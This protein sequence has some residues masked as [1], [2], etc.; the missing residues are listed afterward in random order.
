MNAA[1]RSTVARL[2]VM[3]ILC[4]VSVAGLPAAAAGEE[5]ALF[6]FVMNQSGQPVVDLRTDELRIQQAGGECTVVGLQPE[7]NGMKIALLVD[8]TQAA[9]RSLNSLRDGLN[10]FLEDLPSQHEIGLFTIAGQTRQRV[11]FTTDREALHEEVDNL[12]VESGGGAVLLDGLVETWNRRFD[13]EDAW[14]AFVLVVHDGPEGSGSV[15]E[16]EFNEFVAEL[17]G[18]GAT[19]HAVLVSTRGGGLQTNVSVN[20]TENT[21]GVYKALAAATALPDT[22]RELATTMSAQYD[23]L[24]NR[25]RVVYECEPDN[26]QVPISVQL[27]RPAVGV[28]LFADRRPTP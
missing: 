23:E 27:S 26:P 28:R 11:A 18:R 25:Y 16:H 9:Q 10:A 21:G 3:L 14:P 1:A 17:R 19:V 7:T 13:E 12:F 8:T 24:K 2:A 5:R 6:M 22:L 4:L 20:I 15:Q